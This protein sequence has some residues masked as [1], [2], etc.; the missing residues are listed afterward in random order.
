MAKGDPFLPLREWRISLYR[1][2][3]SPAAVDQFLSTIDATLPPGWVRDRES[4][5]K[6]PH[7]GRIR[8]YLFD[9]GPGDA[10]VGL[11]LRRASETRV[12]GWSTDVLRPP[13][14]GDAPRI[15]RI[16]AEFTNGCVRPAADTAGVRCTRPAFSVRSHVPHGVNQLLNELA[17][18]ADGEWPLPERAKCLWEEVISFGLEEQIALD[19]NDFIRWLADSGWEPAAAPAIAHK[20]FADSRWVAE[21]LAALDR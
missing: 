11:G 21:R 16:V 10:S 1:G 13:P 15:A 7:S 18:T 4:E 8:A 17:D 20:L 6:R 5:R 9:Q 14:S 3:A 12:R 2:A 19:R